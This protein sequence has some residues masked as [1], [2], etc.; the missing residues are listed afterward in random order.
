M[1]RGASPSRQ[2]RCLSPAITELPPRFLVI[3]LKINSRGP[4]MMGTL[5]VTPV[6]PVMVKLKERHK[7]P[8]VAARARAR[9]TSVVSLS[10]LCAILFDSS[11]L[12]L[13][14]VAPRAGGIANSAP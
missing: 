8:A 4:S 7:Q 12:A 5:L 9:S 2:D 6:K 13:L 1:R 11:L 10:L 3:T 14:D